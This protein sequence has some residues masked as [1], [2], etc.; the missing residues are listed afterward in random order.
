MALDERAAGRVR[1]GAASDGLVTLSLTVVVRS[2]ARY[3]A[4]VVGGTVGVE[5]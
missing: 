3:V 4:P 5:L 1:D 2:E